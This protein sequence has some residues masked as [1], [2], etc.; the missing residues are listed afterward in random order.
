M[1][2]SQ[3][4][5]SSLIDHFVPYLPLERKHVILCIEKYL[6]SRFVTPTKKRV[7]SIA[8]SMNVCICSSFTF[9]L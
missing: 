4:I 5:A 1:E 9:Y 3:L 8:D 6:K 7:E 2:E